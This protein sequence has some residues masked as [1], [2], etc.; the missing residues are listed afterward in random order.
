MSS[1]EPTEFSDTEQ[2]SDGKESPKRLSAPVRVKLRA[3]YA[4]VR[5][6]QTSL[7]SEIEWFEDRIAYCT[8]EM[9][10]YEGTRQIVGEALMS[11]G[12]TGVL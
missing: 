9:L 12:D 5:K 3:M 4:D 10:V 6:R 8:D 2:A 7:W 1:T 11:C